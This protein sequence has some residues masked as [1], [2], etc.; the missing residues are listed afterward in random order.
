MIPVI[1]VSID[2]N[3]N[4]DPGVFWLPSLFSLQVL[5]EWNVVRMFV[6]HPVSTPAQVTVAIL[7]YVAKDKPL[8]QDRWFGYSFEDEEEAQV[9]WVVNLFATMTGDEPQE[10]T[11][12]FAVG[13]WCPE[14]GEPVLVG[15][16]PLNEADETDTRV[17]PVYDPK[18]RI[19]QVVPYFT[20]SLNPPFSTLNL[21]WC[22]EP[23]PVAL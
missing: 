12:G 16:I 15:G 2:E 7:A 8:P 9:P 1:A 4:K 17:Q 20:D 6:Y 21:V 18:L 22:V 23:A 10:V 11:Y 5:N 3:D 19:N 13:D 14:I